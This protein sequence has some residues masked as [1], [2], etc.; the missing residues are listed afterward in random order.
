MPKG[1]ERYRPHPP[2]E[3]KCSS[4]DISWLDDNILLWGHCPNLWGSLSIELLNQYFITCGVPLPELRRHWFARLM[5]RREP[6]P[7]AHGVNPRGP[8]GLESHLRL[9]R[10]Q[11][12]YRIA[13]SI[14]QTHKPY[15]DDNVGTQS[16]G[17]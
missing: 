14:N 8:F 11:W 1:H 16:A 13:P 6:R 10:H 15:H 5:S 3:M 9:V 2:T 4:V 7:S 12:L 17:K